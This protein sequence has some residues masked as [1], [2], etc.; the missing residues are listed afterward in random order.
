MSKL[1]LLPALA[2]LL[3]SSPSALAATKAITGVAPVDSPTLTANKK[4]VVYGGAVAFSGEVPVTKAGEKITLRAEVLQPN[5]RKQSSA[6]AE[7]TT[8]G[9][10]AF[11]FTNVPTAQTSYTAVWQSLSP[12]PA[13]SPAV[14]VRVAPRI[15]LALV[16]KVGP[17]VTFSTKA[18][19][20]IPYLGRYVFVQRRDGLGQWGSVKRVVLESNTVATRT[21]VRLPNGLSRIRVLMPQSQVGT[22]YVAGVSRVI[23]VRL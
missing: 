9:A 21:A 20:A 16:R 8:D 4:K 23:L 13:A 11:T 22:G 18:T 19:S 7:T 17:V 10:G 5:G 14:L 2:A 3:L 15:G 1:L 6:I 12:Q